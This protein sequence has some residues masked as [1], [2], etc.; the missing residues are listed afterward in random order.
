MKQWRIEYFACFNT[1]DLER[2]ESLASTECEKRKKYFFHPADKNVRG[3][4][5][6]IRRPA[7]GE[8]GH[9]ER[10]RGIS[11]I[12]HFPDLETSNE[13]AVET[14]AFRFEKDDCAQNAFP[15][16]SAY[17]RGFGM[18]IGLYSAGRLDREATGRDE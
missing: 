1:T 2:Y 17:C 7:N 3:D 9:C 18:G 5:A 8:F 14:S 11:E 10:S 16:S 12:S 4:V 6:S 15:S 13:S